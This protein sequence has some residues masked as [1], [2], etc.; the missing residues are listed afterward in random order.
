VPLSDAVRARIRDG[1]GSGSREVIVGL[2]P[3]H[4]EDA[5]LIGDRAGLKFRTGVEVLESMGSE[6]YA[7]FDV[8]SD[9]VSSSELD[10][11]AQDAGLADLPRQDRNEVV[12][13]LS[14]ESRARQ[15]EDAE[16]W[17]NSDQIQLFDKET[18]KSLTAG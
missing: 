1:G 16:L 13:R 6:F 3:E 18:G 4:F 11:L 8:A 5:S 17:F 2:R 12:A 7:H 15:G 14:A 9:R 10:E